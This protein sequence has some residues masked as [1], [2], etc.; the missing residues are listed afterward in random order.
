MGRTSSNSSKES[1]PPSSNTSS[2]TISGFSPPKANTNH[3]RVKTDIVLTANA[4]NF[5]ISPRRTRSNTKQQNS[6]MKQGNSNQIDES[7]SRF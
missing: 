4:M 7:V 6:T 3:R 1:P 5:S 2:F